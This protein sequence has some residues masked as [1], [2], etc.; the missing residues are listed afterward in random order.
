MDVPT[1]SSSLCG[2]RVSNATGNL[3][4]S[5]LQYDYCSSRADVSLNEYVQVAHWDGYR[6]YR[7]LGLRHPSAKHA[8]QEA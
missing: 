8:H 7:H 4:C 1:A 6:S 5:G 3:I 2:Y